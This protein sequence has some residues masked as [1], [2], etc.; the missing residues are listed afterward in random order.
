MN[1]LAQPKKP[2]PDGEPDKKATPKADPGSLPPPIESIIQRIP[3][4]AQEEVKAILAVALSKTTLY[5]GGLDPETAK[6]VAETEM[7]EETCRLDACKASLQN[8]EKQNQRD[9]EYR[10]KNLNHETLQSGIVLLVTVVGASV[11]L[12]LAAT[13]NSALGTPRTNC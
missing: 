1:E 3:A 8:R 6:T 11:G 9:H 2:A 13:G 4:E 5:G 7:H 12:A 10:K